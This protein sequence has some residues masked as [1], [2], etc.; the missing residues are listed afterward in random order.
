MKNNT[1]NN[2]YSIAPQWV[3]V[4]EEMVCSF[5]DLAN[6]FA[7]WQ[8]NTSDTNARKVWIKELKS[9]YL[10]IRLKMKNYNDIYKEYSDE[11]DKYIFNM[12]PYSLSVFIEHTKI[13]LQF[14]EEIG[15]TKVEQEALD[16]REDSW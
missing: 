10:K 14:I 9:L 13:V 16:W 6:S 15:L 11:I 12:N 4:K 1:Q 7:N 3:T 5:F 2:N 8:V